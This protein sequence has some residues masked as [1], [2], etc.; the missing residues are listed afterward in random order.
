[1][2]TNS[3]TI[4]LG[5]NADYD[6]RTGHILDYGKGRIRQAAKEM[7][8]RQVVPQLVCHS[9]S[10]Y[11]A[12]TADRLAMDLGNGSVQTQVKGWS[13]LS[14]AEPLVTLC[15]K[16]AQELTKI[17]DGITSCALIT[18]EAAVRN[19]APMLDYDYYLKNFMGGCA[20]IQTAGFMVF[21]YPVRRFADLKA[22]NG[23]VLD[24]KPKETYLLNYV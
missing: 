22:S 21:T 6:S 15:D 13:V 14:D 24:I 3:I 10:L 16:V 5:R 1:M 7:H 11:A 18:Y 23:R 2:E 19:I 17:P 8:Q 4:L 12:E 9:M 20:N